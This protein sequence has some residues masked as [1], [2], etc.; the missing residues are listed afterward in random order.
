MNAFFSILMSAWLLVL[1]VTGWCCHPLGHAIRCNAQAA[2]ASNSSSCCEDCTPKPEQSPSPC[3]HEKKCLGVCTYLPE[4]TT[5]FDSE[6]TPSLY[7]AVFLAST[8]AGNHL[9][10]PFRLELP[11]NLVD[12]APPLRT[13]LLHRI[14]LI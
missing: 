9:L 13:H 8:E 1:A 2:A 7:D 5:E 4:K 3:K 12:S 6:N 10:V 11:G 14:L